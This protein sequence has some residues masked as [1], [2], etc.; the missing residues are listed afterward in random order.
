MKMI[1]VNSITL[2]FTADKRTIDCAGD[3]CPVLD[4]C[5]QIRAA[6]Q[7][8]EIPFREVVAAELDDLGIELRIAAFAAAA[9]ADLDPN[10]DFPWCAELVRGAFGWIGVA[11]RMASA[12]KSEAPK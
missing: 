11:R 10:G 5:G 6:L 12:G 4:R 3:S 9:I 1:P 8:S 2:L 7:A